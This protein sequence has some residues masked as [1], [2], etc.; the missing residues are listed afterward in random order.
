MDQQSPLPVFSPLNNI[1]R[2]INGTSQQKRSEKLSERDQINPQNVGGEPSDRPK[3]DQTLNRDLKG[4]L[5]TKEVADETSQEQTAEV[6][7]PPKINDQ[8]NTFDSRN[9]QNQVSR[10]FPGDLLK[11]D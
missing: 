2:K 5:T 6:L 10:D 1:A 8:A 3:T 11:T 4:D 9:L 7:N